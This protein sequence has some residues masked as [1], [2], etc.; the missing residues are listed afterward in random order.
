MQRIQDETLDILDIIY[1]LKQIEQKRAV[2][3]CYLQ[4]LTILVSGQCSC[5]KP[6][7]L[8]FLMVKYEKSKFYRMAFGFIW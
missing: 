8:Q 6:V 2:K 7:N 3:K 1:V 5:I 4:L